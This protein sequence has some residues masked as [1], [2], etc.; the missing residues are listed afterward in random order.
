MLALPKDRRGYP[1]PFIVLF[2]KEGTPRFTIN[3]DR[4]V[5]EA[6]AKN[7]CAICGQHMGVKNRWLVGGPKSALH[8]D[9]AYF[10]TPVH[11][12]CARYAL[13]VCPWLAVGRYQNRIDITGIKPENLPGVML[14]PTQ[15]ASRPPFFVAV[16]VHTYRIHRQG[17]HRLIIPGRPYDGIEIWKDGQL[18][19]C[20]EATDQKT[21]RQ[22]LTAARDF[23]NQ[24]NQTNAKTISLPDS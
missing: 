8:P 22:N 15:D 11:R 24:F 1:I 18:L 6:L 17:L 9:G 3:D 12:E 16:Q 23:Y 21:A 14:D 19:Q 13:K 20:W 5:E 10:D 2:D 4:K 7:L